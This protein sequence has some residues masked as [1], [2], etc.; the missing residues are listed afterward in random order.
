MLKPNRSFELTA[1]DAVYLPTRRGLAALV[2]AGAGMFV[3]GPFAGAK[4]QSRMLDVPRAAGTV[5]ERYDGFA[6]ARGAASSDVAALVAGVNGE[7]RA[8]YA[9]RAQ[10]DNV[11][12][13]AVGRIYALEIMKSAPPKTWFLSESGQ[14]TQK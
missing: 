8:V 9:Q 7:R 3:A 4:A 5:G 13:D 1:M 10:S 12:I 6:A 2:L 14:W 11:S